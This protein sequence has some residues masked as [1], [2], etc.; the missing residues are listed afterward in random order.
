MNSCE[1]VEKFESQTFR[2]HPWWLKYLII[3]V[4]NLRRRKSKL[5]FTWP[6]RDL[7]HIAMCPNWVACRNLFRCLDNLLP[8]RRLAHFWENEWCPVLINYHSVVKYCPF[9]TLPCKQRSIFRF[10]CICRF[11]SDFWKAFKTCCMPSKASNSFI[12]LDALISPCRNLKA[13]FA[14]FSSRRLNSFSAL[15]DFPI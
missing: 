9:Y 3:I 10:A 4:S 7:P 8:K 13:S 6:Q 14:P 12:A 15:S 1:I 5:V 11:L 2:Q